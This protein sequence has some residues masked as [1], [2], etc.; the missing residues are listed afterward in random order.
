MFEILPKKLQKEIICHLQNDQ[1]KLAKQ[2]YD[3]WVRKQQNSH[4]KI[5]I[6]ST[7]N[8]ADNPQL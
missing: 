4:K 7:D 6:T 8:L 5:D 2:T 1:F 3:N